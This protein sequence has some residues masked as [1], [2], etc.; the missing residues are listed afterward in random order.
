MT[1]NKNVSRVIIYQIFILVIKLHLMLIIIFLRLPEG[2]TIMVKCVLTIYFNV[3]F[4]F[5]M[6]NF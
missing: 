4:K 5:V 1:Y 2:T 6:D 3:H